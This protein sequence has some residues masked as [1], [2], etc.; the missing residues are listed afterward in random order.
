MTFAVKVDTDIK[1]ERP[2]QLYYGYIERIN[3]FFKS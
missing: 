1:G 2:P 3:D